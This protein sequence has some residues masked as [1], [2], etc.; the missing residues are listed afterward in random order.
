MAKLDFFKLKCHLELE[1]VELKFLLDL[2]L[3]D[4][5]LDMGRILTNSLHKSYVPWRSL[6]ALCQIDVVILQWQESQ[7]SI[8]V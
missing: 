2:C 3:T 4:E 5:V 8:V 6:V 7:I 1:L